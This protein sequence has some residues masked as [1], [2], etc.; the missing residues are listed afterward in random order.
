M[1]YINI[2]LLWWFAVLSLSCV[3]HLDVT[4]A[5]G[6]FVTPC[7]VEASDS[8]FANQFKIG[9]ASKRDFLA[10]LE[11][12]AYSSPIQWITRIG[13]GLWKFQINV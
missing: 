11:I 5:C 8:E 1:I 13:A 10:M 3:V 7:S 9:L 4:S 12:Q 2:T 6:N